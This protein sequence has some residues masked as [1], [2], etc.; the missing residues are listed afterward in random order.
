ML[1]LAASEYL[2]HSFPTLREGQL[3]RLRTALVNNGSLCQ[4]AATCGMHH[5]ARYHHREMDEPG[6]AR[7]GMLADCFEAFLGALF[8]DRQASARRKA[9][10]RRHPRAPRHTP[11]A[12]HA[13]RGR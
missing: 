7:R 3:S 11:A 2:F 9:L 4:V 8:L 5:V 10:A 1:Q 12:R 13:T 6:A